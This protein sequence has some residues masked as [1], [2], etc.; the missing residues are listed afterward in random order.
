MDDA[1]GA[2]VTSAE[3][4][5]ADAIARQAD[6]TTHRDD[7]AAGREVSETTTDR[8][9]ATGRRRPR[10][11]VAPMSMVVAA[12]IIIIDV[13]TKHW[14][15][16]EL[17]GNREIHVLWTLQWNLSFNTGMAFS[18]G[19]GLGPVIALLAVL[20]VIVLV[21]GSAHVESRLARFAAGMLIGGAVGN[22]G[23][24]LFRGDGWLHGA[25]VDFIDFQ[26]FPI[27]NVAD[28]GVT[29]GATLFALAS[30]LDGRPGSEVGRHGTPDHGDPSGSTDR[31]SA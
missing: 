7:R 22:L 31:R 27:F 3:A 23:D 24:R 13:A 10:L 16:N 14:A 18:K 20:I 2:D 8:T 11:K 15:V 1:T 28:I 6:D 17:A 26:W 21:V 4:S 5:A 19:Q 29:V 9:A 12:V 30:L 25:V